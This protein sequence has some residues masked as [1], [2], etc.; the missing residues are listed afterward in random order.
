[1]FLIGVEHAAAAYATLAVGVALM[2]AL[3]VRRALGRGVS[4]RRAAL[5]AALL[6]LAMAF[7]SHLLYC[8]VDIENVLYS[9]SVG[10]LFAF[11]AQGGMLYGGMLGAVA[12][13]MLVGGRQGAALLESYAPGGAVMIAAYRLF[14]GLM[15][16]GYGEYWTGEA[17]ALCR[18]PFMVYDPYYEG[19]GWALF[20][21]EALVALVLLIVLLC[22]KKPRFEGDGALLL[23]GLTACAQ[24]VL[25]SLR[26]DE[27]L[28]WGF[29]RVDELFSAVCILAV[30]VCYCVRA[31]RGRAVPRTL[32]FILFAAM[33]T[34]C[35][36]LEFA[37]EGRIPFLLFLEAEACYLVMAAACGVMAA[38]IL[39]MRSLVKG[40]ERNV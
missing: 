32:C 6:P 31:G 38:C 39:W 7:G 24:V 18:F 26:R 35:I 14:E 20:M 15:G 21:A 9:R 5:S 17:S 19:W 1:M 10:Y 29:V 23:M 27:F 22:R 30:L 28:R 12:A 4:P 11:W 25:E 8:L 36:L 13:L 33:V 34:L 3:G 2:L 37:T 16:Q 40:K